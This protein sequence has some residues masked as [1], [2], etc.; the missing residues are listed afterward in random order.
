LNAH[1]LHGVKVTWP[2][3]ERKSRQ[4]LN[5]TPI[6]SWLRATRLLRQGS[7]WLNDKKPGNK[8]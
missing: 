1:F 2:S 5:G 6:G 3:A 8:G 7:N 4:N